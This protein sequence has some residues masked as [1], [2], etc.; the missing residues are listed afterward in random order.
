MHAAKI[1]GAADAVHHA[2]SVHAALSSLFL[3]LLLL[4]LQRKLKWK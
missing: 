1:G 3:L 2:V 4:L